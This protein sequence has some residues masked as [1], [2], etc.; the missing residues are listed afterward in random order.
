MGI[1]FFAY[2][3]LLGAL[4]AFTILSMLTQALAV[5]QFYRRSWD[6]SRIVP[7]KGHLGVL[8]TTFDPTDKPKCYHIPAYTHIHPQDTHFAS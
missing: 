7:L 6:A 5:W 2:M 1:I 3:F 8:R 4:F